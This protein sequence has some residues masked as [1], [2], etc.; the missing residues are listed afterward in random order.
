MT[1][2]EQIKHLAKAQGCSY[3]KLIAL[4]PQNDPF[5]SG[6]N[7]NKKA[8]EWFMGLWER[9]GFVS[10]VHLRRIHYR[11]VAEG[12]IVKYDGKP[13]RNTENDWAILCI[14]G[15]QARYLGLI[16]PEAFVDRRNPDA[17]IYFYNSKDEQNPDY[18]FDDV[19]W[20]IPSWSVPET[21]YEFDEPTG[22]VSGY[23]YRDGEQPYH[24]EIWAE[25]S[26]MDDILL[27]I[28]REHGLNIVTS[29]GYQ[30]ITSIVDMCKRVA[31][32]EKPVRIFYISD[33]DPSGDNMPV[34]VARQTEY[35]LQ[36]YAPDGHVK[37]HPLV[38]TEEQVDEF[39]LP[40]TP[41]KSTDK[42]KKQFEDHHGRGA[43]ELDAL[44]GL[45]PG[46][47]RE[48][49]EEAI[50]P[51]RDEELEDRFADA[52]QEAQYSVD[53]TISQIWEKYK[54]PIKE[55]HKEISELYK[56]YYQKVE[57]IKTDFEAEMAP[58]EEKLE[59]YRQAITNELD[60]VYIDLPGRPVAKYDGDDEK[61][62][63]FSS[64]RP[65]LKQLEYYKERQGR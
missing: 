33:F 61:K 48:I 18:S 51:Y 3:R 46:K 64:D 52:E 41:I 5:Y 49:V 44:E 27:P 36:S 20:W 17:H 50:A 57:P 22:D 7:G 28:G 35:W 40:R 47:L 6:T 19:G 65:Y 15:K 37:L 56:K 59:S 53:T 26:T 12:N 21:I 34:A 32:I 16:S 62:W 31:Q 63:L 25:K 13:Y 10:G 60:E 2:Y 23:A 58:L 1:S 30:S 11:I 42:R 14:A 55:L 29:L 4:A 43:T 9:F 45:Y 54:E 8:A 24:V 39:Q 38:L